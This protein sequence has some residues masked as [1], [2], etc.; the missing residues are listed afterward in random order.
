[1]GS[2]V[3][4]VSP[5]DVATTE[6]YRQQKDTAVLCVV[7][8]DFCSST[9]LLERLGETKYDELRRERE[10]VITDHITR[11]SAGAIV[12]MMG[13]GFLAVFSEPSTAVGRSL[14]V[15]M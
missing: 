7:F 11:D 9:K 1:M 5:E 12:K 8:G 14:L 4:Q 15:Q 2:S 13:D 6:H 3:I 10:A